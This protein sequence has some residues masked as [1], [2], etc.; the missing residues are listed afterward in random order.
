[1]HI[2]FQTIRMMASPLWIS[3]EAITRTQV[4]L[5]PDGLTVSGQVLLL[6]YSCTSCLTFK[7]LHFRKV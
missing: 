1:M 6:H 2:M 5:L 4:I 3:S 7:G